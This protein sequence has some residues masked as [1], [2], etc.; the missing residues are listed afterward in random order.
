MDLVS[1]IG[2]SCPPRLL[3]HVRQGRV[4]GIPE[5]PVNL[6]R[7]VDDAPQ[8]VRHKVFRHRHDCGEIHLLFNLIRS[9]QHH[10]LALVQLDSGIRNEPLDALLLCEQRAVRIPLH[11][12]T[13]HHVERSFR[14]TDPP[15]AMCKA[16][17]T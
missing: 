4:G 13:H 5:R 8:A 1:T 15:H 9:M 14:L 6:N 17:R 11:R 10:Q 7:P 12:S 16:S 3:Q 2:K